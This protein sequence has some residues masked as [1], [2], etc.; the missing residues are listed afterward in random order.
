MFCMVLYCCRWTNWNSLFLGTDAAAEGLAARLGTSKADALT[1]VSILLHLARQRC[2]LPVLMIV[3]FRAITFY[4]QL[5]P[6]LYEFSQSSLLLLSSFNSVGGSL[7]LL[8]AS[9]CWLPLYSMAVICVFV[10][11]SVDCLT[12]Q[13]G[14]SSAAVR[15]AFAETDIVEETRSFLVEQG[16]RLDAVTKVS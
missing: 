13:E 6:M 14:S 5:H 3:A 10:A 1:A 8:E 16:V 12:L 7:S 9:F 4:V 15:L 2:L 11:L